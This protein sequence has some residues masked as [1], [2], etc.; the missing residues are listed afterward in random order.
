MQM[1]AAARSGQ[2]RNWRFDNHTIITGTGSDLFTG[3]SNFHSTLSPPGSGLHVPDMEP[4]IRQIERTVEPKALDDLW[5]RAGEVAYDQ[6]QVIPLFWLPTEVAYNPTI[7][8]G[9]TF[10]GGVTGSWTHVRTIK[11]AR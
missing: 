4:V 6:H 8:A 11:A 10:P 7:V 5:R 2:Q 9:W 1:D 3:I